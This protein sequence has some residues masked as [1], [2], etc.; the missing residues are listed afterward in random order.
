[1]LCAAEMHPDDA[2][3]HYSHQKWIVPDLLSQYMDI[4][5]VHKRTVNFFL[6]NIYKK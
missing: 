1:M 3:K 5:S 4:N 2:L 6:E